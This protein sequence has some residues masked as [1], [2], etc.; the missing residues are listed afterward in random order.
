MRMQIF[1]GTIVSLCKRLISS[2]REGGYFRQ[3]HAHTV[4][5]VAKV[6]KEVKVP[7]E[8][9]HNQKLDVEVIFFQLLLLSPLGSIPF[10]GT[11]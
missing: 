1:S 8:E 4:S 11:S 10:L 7:V 3:N 2:K 5:K 9:L 6:S